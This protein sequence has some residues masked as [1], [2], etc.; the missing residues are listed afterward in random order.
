MD[1]LKYIK[2]TV[3][4]RV[5]EQDIDTLIHYAKFA[6][7]N[8][9]IVDV[10][11]CQGASAFSL[12]FGSKPSVKIYTIDPNTGPMFYEHKKKLELDDRV[13]FLH[14]ISENIASTWDKPIDIVFVDGVHSASG[15]LI[16][17]EGFCPHV[18]KGGYCLFHD[19]TLYG[20]TV[21]KTIDSKEGIY[22][23]KLKVVDNIYI[24]KKL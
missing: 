22:Y 21:G 12:A 24:S 11:T 14:D 6:E 16:D 9:V 17:I 8:G 2:E 10:G 19:Y 23:K 13:I 20:N 7:E 15:V 4:G 18:K 1:K 5:T 3:D